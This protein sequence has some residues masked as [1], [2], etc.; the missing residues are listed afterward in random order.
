MVTHRSRDD[1]NEPEARQGVPRMH[2]RESLA[3]DLQ[4]LGLESGDTL[5]VHSSFKSLG[6][7]EG[8]AGAVIGALED[9]LGPEGL[10][11]MPT[12]NITEKTYALRAKTWNLETTP[13]SVGWLTEFFRTQPGVYR[14]DHYSHSVAARG[15][16]AEQ[17]VSDHLSLI[18][19]EA[20]WDR[21][22][23]G[24]TY[25]IQSPMMKAYR[26]PA[27]KVLML[28][29][30]HTAA[31]Y[32]HVVE[33]LFWAWRKSIVYNAPYFYI[34][35]EAV[36]AFWD[37]LHRQRRGKVGNAECRLHGIRVFVVSVLVAV[38][39]DPK[40]FFKGYQE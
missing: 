17:F 28:G 33:T 22:P 31:T 4:R 9:A 11:L 40:R 5:F 37:P 19:P 34:D 39:Q 38:K 10:L 8:G 36:F 16:D 1:K 29:T 21:A 12:F 18:G 7:V 20:P 6:P 24:R 15:K 30:D 23:W 25:G 32:C 14:S 35:R 27:G 3:A 26:S 2:T 13:S